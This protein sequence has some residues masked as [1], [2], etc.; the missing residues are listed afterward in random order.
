VSFEFAST[1]KGMLMSTREE[2]G[3][4]LKRRRHTAMTGAYLYQKTEGSRK[5]ASGTTGTDRG[6]QTRRS[7]YGA[8]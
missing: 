3:K 4:G 1:L 5:E 6:I 7:A 8:G 2:L